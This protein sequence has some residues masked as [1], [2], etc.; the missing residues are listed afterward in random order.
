MKGFMIITALL[1]SSLSWAALPAPSGNYTGQGQLTRLNDGVHFDYDVAYTIAPNAITAS[2]IYPNGFS[3]TLP[4]TT[5]D[6]T[7]G[8]FN[9]YIQGNP[10]GAG[11]CLDISCHA[12]VSFPLQGVIQK[13]SMNFTWNANGSS[14]KGTLIVSGFNSTTNT[15]FEDIVKN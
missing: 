12:D 14:N 6:T 13:V 7:L 11:Y 8:R 10:V 9:I 15:P 4:F 2:Y 3:Y 1:F 5:Q